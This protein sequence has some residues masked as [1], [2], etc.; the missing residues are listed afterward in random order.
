MQ[1]CGFVRDFKLEFI[2]KVFRGTNRVAEPYNP[3]NPRTKQ[4]GPNWLKALTRRIV[5]AMLRSRQRTLLILVAIVLLYEFVE[6]LIITRLGE[7]ANQVFE[8]L[9]YIFLI[10]AAAW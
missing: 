4:Q 6:R 3:A 8:V 5:P 2:M 1:R 10:P 9:H 7:P